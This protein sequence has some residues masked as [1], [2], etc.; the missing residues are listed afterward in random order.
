MSGVGQGQ[1]WDG[2]LVL[3][4]HMQPLPAG[5]QHVEQWTGGEQVRHLDSSAQHLL[6][7]IQQQQQLLLPH[8]LHQ[9]FQQRL[10]SRFLNA[11]C[12]ANGGEDQRE[13][14]ERSQIHE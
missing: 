9:A 10:P 4:A 2:K 8:H 7:V 13:V 12:L 1:W 6:E 5:Q 3:G 14:T 11:Q